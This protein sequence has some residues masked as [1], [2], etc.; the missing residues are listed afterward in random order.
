MAIDHSIASNILASVWLLQVMI[1]KPSG[2][3]AA[4]VRYRICPPRLMSY[5]PVSTSHIFTVLSDPPVI[6]LSPS[7]EKLAQPTEAELGPDV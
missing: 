7:G 6:T 1:F 3:K 5:F 4:D 2:E